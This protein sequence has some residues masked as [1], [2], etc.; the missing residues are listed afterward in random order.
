MFQ[1]L[2]HPCSLTNFNPRIEMHGEDPKPAADLSFTANLPNDK[3]ALF[4]ASLRDFLF[5]KNG[6][7]TPDTANDSAAAPHLRFPKLGILKW[8]TELVGA[9]V[10]IHVGEISKHEV[11]L[12]A[13]TVCKFKIDPQEGGTCL[14]YFLV[15]CHP[16]EKQSGKLAFMIGRD[17]DVTV[18]PP[19]DDDPEPQAQIPGGE[20]G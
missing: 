10:T 12:P 18:E 11:A 2:K 8:N 3:L 15:Q 6:D 16:D 20:V 14:V 4:D 9:K 7:A 5:W 17:F 19:G 13:A 1:L